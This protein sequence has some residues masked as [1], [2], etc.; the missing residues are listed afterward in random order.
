MRYLFLLISCVAWGQWTGK[1]LVGNYAT[2]GVNAQS[3]AAPANGDKIYHCGLVT[4]SDGL[5]SKTLDKVGFLFGSV[6][7]AGG[8]T[9]TVSLQDMDLTTGPPVRSD[10][11]QD[12]IYTILN[13]DASFASNTYYTATLTSNRTVSPGD[14]LC[15][16]WEY[17]SY[18]GADTFNINAIVTNSPLLMTNGVTRL[19]TGSY[20]DRAALTNVHFGFTDGTYGTLDGN[21]TYSALGTFTYN[22]ASTPDEYAGSFT[23]DQNITIDAV[24]ASVRPAGSTSDFDIVLYNG[25]TSIGSCSVDAHN[26]PVADYP[27]LCTLSSRIILTTGN[28]YRIAVKPTTANNVSVRYRDVSVAALR[29]ITAYGTNWSST[30][31]TDAGSWAADTTTRLMNVGYRIVSTAVAGGGSFVV[32]Q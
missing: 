10:N 1:A 26:I 20:V 25:T 14:K 17:A 9:V 22:S 8:S 24:F 28:T 5:S 21:L 30:S 3:S 31:R 19:N 12:Q 29:A 13:A 27:A 32:A 23:V 16:V 15:V 2:Y 11:T 18:G 6:T 7:K 4:T